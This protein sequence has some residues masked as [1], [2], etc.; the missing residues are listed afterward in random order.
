M[1]YDAVI[2]GSGPNGLAAAI[3]LARAGRSVLVIEGAATIGGGTRTQ[4]ITLPGFRHDLCSAIHPLGLGSPF[5]RNLPLQNF[6]LEWVQPA[7]PLAHPFD[8]GTAVTLHRSIDLTAS[9]IGEDGQAWAALMEPLAQAWPKLAPALLGPLPLSPNL[10]A[11]ARF[12]I[13]ALP[14][15][16]ALAEYRFQGERARALFAGLAA[17]S[18]L[19]LDQMLTASF[20]LVLGILAHA[21]G[22]PAARGG[23]QSIADAMVRYLQSLGGDIVCGWTVAL[24]DELPPSK[25]VLLDVTPRQLLALAGGRLP[26]GYARRLADYRYGPGVFKIDYALDGPV[27]WTAEECRMAGT[28]HVGGTLE[29]IVLSER[30]TTLGKHP[31]HPYVLIAQQSLFDPTCAPEGKQTLWAYCHVPHGSE[32][33]MT[34]GVEAQIERFAPGFRDLISGQIDADCNGDESLQPQL[35]RRR[36]QRRRPGSAPA[37]DPASAALAALCHAA[38]GRLPLLIVDAARRRGPWDVRGSRGAGCVGGRTA[39][40]K[41]E[42]VCARKYLPAVSSGRCP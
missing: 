14:S 28:V 19:P 13:N 39:H 29:E 30:Q 22:W 1:S 5:F 21:V 41:I 32:E 36:H 18:F 9:S 10:P 38:E 40:K 37:L 8:D 26:A 3:T 15:A 12:G 17:H 24:L 33:D 25:A 31:D 4:E 2:V 34:G 6:G 23:S 16:R 11:L 7:I 35:H 20:G 27:P 42:I